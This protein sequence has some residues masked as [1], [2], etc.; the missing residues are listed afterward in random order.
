M[1]KIA[2][3]ARL[4]GVTTR[5]LRYYDQRGLFKP[6]H[7]DPATGY[8]YYHTGQVIS[9]QRILALRE[10]GLPLEQ[11]VQIVHDQLPPADIACLLRAHQQRIE[12]RLTLEHA[13]QQET[14]ARLTALENRMGSPLD[15][16]VKPLLSLKGLHIQTTVQSGESIQGLFQRFSGRLQERGLYRQVQATIGFYPRHLATLG[17]QPLDEPFQ[18]DALFVMPGAPR[19]VPV[20]AGRTL[21]ATACH[22]VTQAACALHIGPYHRLFETYRPLLAYIRQYGYAVAGVPREVYL[23]SR[24]TPEDC[25]TEIQIPI[26]AANQGVKLPLKVPA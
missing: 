18:F 15:V 10:M 5:L 16:V 8:R 4:T 17:G 13:R 20:E 3:F 2:D 6:G 21:T 22:P 7:I 23:Q 25:I 26:S 12:A 14:A 9:L 24:S 11:I 19:T 1:L